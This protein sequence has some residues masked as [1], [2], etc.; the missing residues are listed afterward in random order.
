MN[1][2]QKVKTQ[3]FGELF[4]KNA[5]YL[6]YM[7]IIKM[8]KVKKTFFNKFPEISG[9]IW[10]NFRKFPLEN[11]RKFPNSQPYSEIRPWNVKARVNRSDVMS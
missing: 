6:F 4:V 3:R 11:F 7:V 1:I 10:I 8:Y 5:Y 2:M 9:M